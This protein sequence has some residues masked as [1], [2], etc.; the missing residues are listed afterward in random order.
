MYT[1]KCSCDFK[2]KV[3]VALQHAVG[4]TKGNIAASW[5]C[6]VI[7]TPRPLL[8]LGNSLVPIV[9][10]GLVDHTDDL[11]GCWEEKVT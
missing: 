7:A 10:D 4:R 9:Q 6:V 5:G 11:D 1:L 3:K 2:I 8:L